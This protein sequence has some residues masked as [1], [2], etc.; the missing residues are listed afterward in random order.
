[1]G[2]DV[3]TQT[4]EQ[5][6]N[7]MASPDIRFVS[8]VQHAANRE[9]FRVVKNEVGG[10][11]M[12]GSVVQRIVAP[13]G[14]DLIA[15]LQAEG[16]DFAGN[17]SVEVKAN[18]NGFDI[19]TQTGVEKFD[20]G[21]FKLKRVSSKSDSQI[22]VITGDLKPEFSGTGISIKSDIES[23]LNSTVV[24]VDVEQTYYG[25]YITSMTAMEALDNEIYNLAKGVYAIGTA[26][27]MDN[28]SR[29]RSMYSMVDGFKTF[30]G[31]LMAFVEDNTT[32]NDSSKE[33]TSESLHMSKFEKIKLML[34]AVGNIAG[35]E[36]KNEEYDMGI[37]AEELGKIVAK[38]VSDGIAMKADTP[39]EK[40][41]LD[42]KLDGIMADIAAIKKE[43]E[44]LEIAT[45]AETE[46]KEINAIKA[47]LEAITAEK[48]ELIKKVKDM[49]GEPEGSRQAD[50]P[51]GSAK[52]DKPK[53]INLAGITVKSDFSCFNRIFPKKK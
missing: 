21:S 44:E 11:S 19:Y 39:D 27:G 18:H 26:A 48:E 36:H 45:K 10:G 53:D 3:Q 15:V 20:S 12:G 52:A 22:L 51:Q 34:A 28:K 14:T 7:I 1:M 24:N 33:G 4:K 41:T 43:K 13:E 38:A 30:L 32:K 16:I 42:A 23:P 5:E 8:L 25:M 49:E 6:A 29:L 9:P 46:Q 37:N 40:S 17:V 2:L 35:T 47:Q 50:A 31:S